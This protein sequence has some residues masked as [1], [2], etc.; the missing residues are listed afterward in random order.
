MTSD[1]WAVRPLARAGRVGNGVRHLAAP[2]GVS[3]PEAAPQTRHLSLVTRHCAREAGAGK[4]GLWGEV[5]EGIV[6]TTKKG[7]YTY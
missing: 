6:G 3:R 4:W 2:E 7:D 5:E 1:E